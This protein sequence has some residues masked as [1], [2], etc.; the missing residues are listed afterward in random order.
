MMKKLSE[1]DRRR[2]TSIY[3][4]PDLRRALKLRAIEEDRS[5]TEIII[6][7]LREKLASGKTGL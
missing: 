2:K 7:A 1:S 3:L 6:E 5:A 4:P